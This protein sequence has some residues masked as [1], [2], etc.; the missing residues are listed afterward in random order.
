MRMKDVDFCNREIIFCD[1]KGEQDL[2]TVLLDSIASAMQ[3]HYVIPDS[4]E[5]KGPN[6]RANK[7]HQLDEKYYKKPCVIPPGLTKSSNPFHLNPSDTPLPH[8]SY[9]TAMIS[10]PCGNCSATWKSEPP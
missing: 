7:R 2:V 5:Y 4:Q 1:G 10:A 6:S 3:V 9:R 8:I